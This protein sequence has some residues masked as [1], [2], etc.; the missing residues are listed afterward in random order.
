MLEDFQRTCADVEISPVN[1]AFS[2]LINHS[3]LSAER[4]DGI[5]LGASKISQLTDNLS[6]FNQGPLDQSIIE[7]LDRGWEVIKP[8]YFQYFRP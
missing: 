4:G 5:I 8:N 3:K 1:A 6:A 7:V 2:W